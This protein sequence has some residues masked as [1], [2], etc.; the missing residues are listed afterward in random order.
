ME[1]ILD[2]F[3]PTTNESSNRMTFKCILYRK[4]KTTHI[5]LPKHM[6]FFSAAYFSFLSVQG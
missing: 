4:A 6:Q 3:S 5:V 2:I 1:Q